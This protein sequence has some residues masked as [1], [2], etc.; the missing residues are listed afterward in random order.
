MKYDCSNEFDLNE[1]YKKLTSSKNCTTVCANKYF[2]KY[3]E[4]TLLQTKMERIML[5]E[6]Y[7]PKRNSSI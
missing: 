2:S 6:Q 3:D 5:S 1:I 4:L 7:A